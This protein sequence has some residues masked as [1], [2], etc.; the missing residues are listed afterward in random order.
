MYLLLSIVIS[1]I[2]LY[3]IN[4]LGQGEGPTIIIVF[5]RILFVLNS[6]NKKL[7]NSIPTVMDGKEEPEEKYWP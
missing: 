6:I 1:T 5:I 7:K 4:F 3:I 2:S